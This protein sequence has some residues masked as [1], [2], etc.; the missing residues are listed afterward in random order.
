MP[1]ELKILAT[2]WIVAQMAWLALWATPMV[3][4]KV[5]K[6]AEEPTWLV[7][8]HALGI[9]LVVANAA[10]YVMEVVM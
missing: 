10:L 1:L 5:R 6:K 7:G 4:R 3:M 9:V 2:A 8:L